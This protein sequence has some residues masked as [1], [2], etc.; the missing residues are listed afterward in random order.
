MLCMSAYILAGAGAAG[1]EGVEVDDED[2]RVEVGALV[3]EAASDRTVDDAEVVE[4]EGAG[5][6][7]V[8]GGGGGG[9]AGWG[10]G[11]ASVT[12]DDMAS[13]ALADDVVSTVPVL[14]TPSLIA[15]A[16]V[17]DVALD[18]DEEAALSSAAIIVDVSMLFSPSLMSALSTS[19]G[20][21]AVAPAEGTELEDEDSDDSG[22]TPDTEVLALASDG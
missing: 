16:L 5:E 18:E 4:V 11:A 14:A 19:A 21:S 6:G 10:G 20:L 12:G 9:V 7:S 8:G 1:A 13:E 17:D 2:D 15:A 3:A 22:C